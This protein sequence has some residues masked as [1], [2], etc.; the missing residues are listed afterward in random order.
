[1]TDTSDSATEL[2]GWADAMLSVN[3]R[4]AAGWWARSVALLTRQAL[5]TALSELWKAKGVTAVSTCSIR[6]QLLCLRIYLGDRILAGDLAHAW[7]A[8]SNACHHHPY[9]LPPTLSEL[10]SWLQTVRTGVAGVGGLE[11]TAL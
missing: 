9:E 1:M 3:R 8:L 4:A 7:S 2:L 10:Q 6:V 11:K 5:E